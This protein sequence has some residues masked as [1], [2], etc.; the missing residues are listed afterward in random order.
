MAIRNHIENIMYINP[1]VSGLYDPPILAYY[2][3]AFGRLG[4]KIASEII[5]LSIIWRSKHLYL[6]LPSL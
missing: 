1:L 6:P 2:N 3:Y 4:I 5:I